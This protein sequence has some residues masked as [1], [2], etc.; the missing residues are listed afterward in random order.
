VSIGP[1]LIAGLS[2]I[3]GE[4]VKTKSFENPRYLG[5]PINITRLLS[6]F[7]VDE[8][9]IFD[10]SNRFCKSGTS[11]QVLEGILQ[12]AFMPIS[13]GGGITTLQDAEMIFALG[14]DKVILKSALS[15]ESTVSDIASTYGQQAIIGC[16]NI[17]RCDE[18]L[19]VNETPMH[20]EELWEY[21]MKLIAFGVGELVFQD[22]TRD[23]T[24]SGNSFFSEVSRIAEMSEVPISL[25][26][27]IQDV[28]EA[29]GVFNTSKI[30]GVIGSSMFVFHATRDTVFINYPRRELWNEKLKPAL[31]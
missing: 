13:Y 27:G 6:R 5:D 17:Y 26:G 16:L 10:I 18:M 30:N 20:F 3:S 11:H 1:R 2:L 14:F 31:K 7:E 22:I 4:A 29:A 23:G 25:M 9:A 21:C 8:L 12:S 15:K 24:R 19:M 28:D